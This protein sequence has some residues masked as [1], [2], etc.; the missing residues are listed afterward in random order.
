MQTTPAITYIRKT[1]FLLFSLV[2]FCGAG[3]PFQNNNTSDENTLKALFIYNFT[4]HIEWPLNMQQH[5]KFTISIIGNSPVKEKLEDIMKGRKVFDRTVEIKVIHD[6][7]EIT[8]SHILFIPANNSDKINK[9]I[10]QYSDK[11]ILIISESKG[12][13][14]KGSG[15]NI[16]EKDNHLKFELNNAA[17]KKQGLKISNHLINLSNNSR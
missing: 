13:I 1:A 15:I 8:S 6:L 5:S 2:I 12:M 17:L 9:I 4:K 11:G 14:G 10:D 3:I 16:I 7:S